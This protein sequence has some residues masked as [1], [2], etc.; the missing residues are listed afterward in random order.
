MLVTSLAMACPF[1]PPEKQ[2]LLE[3]KTL[4]DRAVTMTTILELSALDRAQD[5]AAARH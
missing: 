5:G 2:A 1:A 3:A 4:S